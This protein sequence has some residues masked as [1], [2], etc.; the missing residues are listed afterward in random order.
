MESKNDCPNCGKALSIIKLGGE[1]SREVCNHFGGC[2]FAGR[3]LS[4]EEAKAR[5][6]A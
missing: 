2:G 4:N 5:V 3:T 6:A 1:A